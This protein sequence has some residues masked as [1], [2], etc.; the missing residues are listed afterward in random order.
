MTKSSYADWL[1]RYRFATL[2]L[3]LVAAACAI[4]GATRLTVEGDYKIF[5]KKDSPEMVATEALEEAFSKNETLLIVVAPRL[6]L[7]HI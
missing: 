2:L 5:F 7:I 4:A 1:H 6:S 3:I